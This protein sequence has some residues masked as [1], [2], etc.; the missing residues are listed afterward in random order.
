MGNTREAV[1]LDHEADVFPINITIGSISI[2]LPL[3]PP[4]LP[5]SHWN[6]PSMRR[7]SLALGIDL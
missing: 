7:W 4:F 2:S 6:L 1:H 3:P 5:L